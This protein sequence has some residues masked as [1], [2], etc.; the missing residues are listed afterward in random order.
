MGYDGDE[1]GE[2]ASR[3]AL[4]ILL[5]EGLAVRRRALRRAGQARSG[6]AATRTGRGGAAPRRSTTA[7]DFVE[8]EIDR[9]IVRRGA[10]RS[11]PAR[12]GGPGGG[13]APASDP[14]RH[15]ALRL[16]TAG[17]RPPGRAGGSPLA[18]PG[19]RPKDALN[20]PVE[21]KRRRTDR[22]TCA[23]GEDA[24]LLQLLLTRPAEVPTCAELPPPEAFLDPRVR[25][26]YATFHRLYESRTASS[27]GPPDARE[28]LGAARSDGRGY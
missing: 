17:G 12:Q 3:R 26:I 8:L 18:A 5:G 19:G 7:P 14:R 4:A 23:V 20:A 28:V 11:P 27:H 6:L 21:R 24:G 16:R 9:L 13:R 15:P 10:S 1:A 25:N 2:N 22:V